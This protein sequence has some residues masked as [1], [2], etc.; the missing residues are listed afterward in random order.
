ML[1][2]PVREDARHRAARRQAEGVDRHL[3]AAGMAVTDLDVAVDHHML[4][5]KSHGAHADGIAELLQ[6]VLERGDARVAVAVADGA[7]AG[8]ALAENHA[9]V[10]GPAKPDPDDGWLAGKAA[11]AEGDEAVEI[12]T[13]DALDPVGGEQH[14]VVGAEQPALVNRDQVDPFSA[15]L[16]AIFD[17]RRADSDIVVMVGPPQRMHAVRAQ[18][19]IRRGIGGGAAQRRL[20]RDRAALDRRLVAHLHI[21]A[22]GAGIAAH[23]PSVFLGGDV[24]VEHGAQHIGGQVAILAVGG[25]FQSCQVVVW[26][27]DGGLRHQLVRRRLDDI[28]RDHVCLPAVTTGY[29]AATRVSGSPSGRMVCPGDTMVKRTGS[30]VTSREASCIRTLVK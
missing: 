17:F 3:H 7:Q 2:T 29:S 8:G 12:E 5:D 10:L 20:Q 26:N 28:Y 25:L 18:R 15:G 23:G 4:A 9:A 16:V 22:R 13:L 11:L 24:I 1:D 30:R 21:P 19:H 6:L 27:L 14:P